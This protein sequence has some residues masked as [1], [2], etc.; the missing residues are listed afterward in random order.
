[1]LMADGMRRM[2]QAAKL[3]HAASCIATRIPSCRTSKYETNGTAGTKLIGLGGRG[4]YM[5][6]W[7]GV[8]VVL[9]GIW[10]A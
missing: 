5:K 7:S 10:C 1:L 9:L 3:R 6:R 2:A 8:E 4:K